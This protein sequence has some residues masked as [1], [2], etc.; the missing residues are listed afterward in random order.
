LLPLLKASKTN[1]G[2]YFSP[3]GG[4]IKTGSSISKADVFTRLVVCLG[5]CKKIV[6]G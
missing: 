2:G 6:S 5:W 3:R 1:N 4:K